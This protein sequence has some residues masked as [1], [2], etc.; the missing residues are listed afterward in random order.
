MA[1]PLHDPINKLMSQVPAVTGVAFTDLDG[2]DIAVVPREARETL[3]LCAAY[4]GIALRRL[5]AAEEEAGR[6]GIRRVVVRSP[7]GAVLSLK[8]GGD[9]QLVVKVEGDT[10]VGSVLSAARAAARALETA[11]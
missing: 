9:Y 5:S 3:R 10:P 7:E 2:E 8:V 4:N 11:I 6:G 1:D